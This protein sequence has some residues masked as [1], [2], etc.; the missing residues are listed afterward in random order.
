MRQKELIIKKS[1]FILLIIALFLLIGNQLIVSQNK[2]IVLK[3]E[4]LFYPD[5]DTI[6]EES[7]SKL[8]V[9]VNNM[10]K[11]KNMILILEGHT[12]NV[13]NPEGEMLLSRQRAL[14]IAIYL[15]EKGIDSSRIQTTGYGSNKL[16]VN[17]IV[18]AN[19]RVE[20]K[21]LKEI[22]TADIE[23]SGNVNLNEGEKKF[24]V[25]VVDEEG[26]GLTANV[27]IQKKENEEIISLKKE[28]INLSMTTSLPANEEFILYVTAEGFMPEKSN[29]ETNETYKKV[30]MKKIA[31]G[32]VISLDN[33]YFYV[34]QPR[35]KKESYDILNDL[36]KV[37]DENSNIKVEI[38]GH[39]DSP[40]MSLSEQRA[41]AIVKFLINKGISEDRLTAKGMSNKEPVAPNNTELNKQ[42]NRRVEFLF[43]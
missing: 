31:A 8:Q 28:K 27:E 7:M 33:I 30:V 17:Q 24:S 39:T 2:E 38:R 43:F 35:I 25:T 22:K 13:G 26:K 41:Q 37:L 18:D 10:A 32:Q 11:D 40:Y 42:K 15:K 9:L 4:I 20:A 16:K 21:I 3:E 23:K 19:R 29:I 12:N 5:T 14:K 6:R 34:S 36:V 1:N